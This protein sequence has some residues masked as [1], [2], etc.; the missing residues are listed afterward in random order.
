MR[1][2]CAQLMV[3]D[4]LADRA[5]DCNLLLDQNLGREPK[6]YDGL[7]TAGSR[8]L[9]GSQYVLLRPKFLEKRL[10]RITGSDK[11][12]ISRVLIS[13][14]G[15]DEGYATGDALAGLEQSDLPDSTRVT[16]C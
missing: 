9:I 2:S 14:G 3:I 11:G 1:S 12:A 4:D 5:H 7:I 6:D 10:K 16:K 13:M 15:V 8:R